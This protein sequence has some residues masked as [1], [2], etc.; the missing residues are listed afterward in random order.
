MGLI[1]NF[2]LASR[3]AAAILCAPLRG[4]IC[5]RKSPLNSS[6]RQS[7]RVERQLRPI[8]QGFRRLC[9]CVD[10]GQ[11]LDCSVY[12]DAM[13]DTDI[14]VEERTNAAK[15]STAK[16]RLRGFA[17]IIKQAIYCRTVE[18]S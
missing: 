2:D 18:S 11:L 3:A 5:P 14:G 7:Y 16:H 4:R 8:N 12:V 10:I 9:V 13:M 15:K 17:G 1:Y 6:Y